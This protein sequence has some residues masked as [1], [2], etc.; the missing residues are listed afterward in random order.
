M[1]AQNIINIGAMAGN[2]GTIACNSILSMGTGDNILMNNNNI[3]SVNQIN[4]NGGNLNT[5][6]NLYVAGVTNCDVLNGKTQNYV[7]LTNSPP[8]EDDSNKIA[9]TTF[10]QQL[11]GNAVITKF[12]ATSGTTNSSFVGN[13]TIA[14]GSLVS[15]GTCSFINT[16]IT[17]QMNVP[18]TSS[19]ILAV[20]TFSSLPWAT[21]PNPYPSSLNIPTTCL[22]GS[23]AGVV[24][25][26]TATLPSTAT[27]PYTLSIIAS[28]TFN[29]LPAGTQFS[30]NLQNIIQAP[31][32]IN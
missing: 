30:F 5:T 22:T 25:N 13:A 20:I 9:T 15:Y 23:S 24:V 7:S 4:G 17:I 26:S 18:I 6:S 31:F 16:P 19:T 14:S 28:L 8:I 12:N 3:T 1:N 27:P 21:W 2:G 11:T 29:G 10:V 32:S